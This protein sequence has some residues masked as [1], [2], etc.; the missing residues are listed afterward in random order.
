[1]DSYYK[2]LNI[3]NCKSTILTH[4]NYLQ[5]LVMAKN[6]WEQCRSEVKITA[7]KKVKQTTPTNNEKV[8]V[9]SFMLNNAFI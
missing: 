2:L 5:S 6:I 4:N 9:N 7:A 8:E 3:K 1:M